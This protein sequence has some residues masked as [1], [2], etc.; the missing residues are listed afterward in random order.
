MLARMLLI[1]L[2]IVL[3]YNNLPAFR[4]WVEQTVSSIES[5]IRDTEERSE[6]KTVQHAPPREH[7]P[8][9]GETQAETAAET[10][11]AG[12]DD[13]PAGNGAPLH[14][15]VF[16]PSE[17]EA[18]AEERVKSSWEKLLSRVRRLENRWSRGE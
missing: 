8:A 5:A 13:L 9:S 10:P 14:D 17:R 4:A 16:A 11:P 1:G 15:G 7:M 18:T 12:D 6:Q 3:A 2:I